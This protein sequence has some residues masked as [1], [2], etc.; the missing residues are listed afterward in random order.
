[1]VEVRGGQME[2][3]EVDE[4][5]GQEHRQVGETYLEDEISLA[6]V[7]ASLTRRFVLRASSLHRFLDACFCSTV[8][9]V[10]D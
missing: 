6:I 10:A 4:I 2:V 5:V 8:G 1:M 9:A 3:R 7:S